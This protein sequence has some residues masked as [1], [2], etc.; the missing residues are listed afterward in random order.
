MRQPPRDALQGLSLAR[1]QMTLHEQVAMFEKVGHLLIDPLRP[2]GHHP[3]RLRG[4]AAWQGR[5]LGLEFLAD[6]RHG[7]QHRLDDFGELYW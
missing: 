2:A 4:A 5:P 1:R 7:T 3:A 6:P